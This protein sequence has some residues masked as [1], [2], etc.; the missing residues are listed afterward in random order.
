M[1]EYQLITDLCE[2]KVFRSKQAADAMSDSDRTNLLYATLLATIAGSLDT[3]T[4]GWATEYAGQTA[5]FNNFDHFRPSG[6]DL[7][8][9]LHLAQMD[10]RLGTQ[11]GKMI[12]V[13]KSIGNGTASQSQIQELL[14]RLERSLPTLDSRLRVARRTIV[15]WDKTTPASRKAGIQNIITV[16]R[17]ASPRS[18][19]IPYMKTLLGGPAGHFGKSSTLKKAAALAG[20]GLA[21]FGLGYKMSS[22]DKKFRVGTR[23]RDSIELDTGNM[24][25]EDRATQLSYIAQKLPEHPAVEKLISVNYIADGISAFVR[26]KDGNAYEFEI[27]PARFAKGHSDKRTSSD[28]LEQRNKERLEK[29]EARITEEQETQE[30]H[31]CSNGWNSTGKDMWGE[32]CATCGG[33]GILT[34]DGN[35]VEDEDELWE[36]KVVEI[37]ENE[38]S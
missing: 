37:D 2:S 31:A 17:S 30:C 11:R 5:A 4:S 32:T 20:I 6:T 10:G 3:K 24:L 1:S 36:Y 22:P 7:Y 29:L 13:L 19:V 34:L 27:R 16:A 38:I 21:G 25:A 26:T 23:F 33:K 15:S 14:L 28:T 18:E 8:V 9:L 35:Y 12:R